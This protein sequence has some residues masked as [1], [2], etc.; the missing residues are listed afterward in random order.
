MDIGG[1]V[2]VPLLELVMFMLNLLCGLACMY[3]GARIARDLS[4]YVLHLFNTEGRLKLSGLACAW[5]APV[6]S[7][8]Y[9]LSPLSTSSHG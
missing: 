5:C 9:S 1:I 4:M 2:S 8:S 7:S 3:A 6:S